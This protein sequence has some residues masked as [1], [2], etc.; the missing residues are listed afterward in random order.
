ML[1]FIYSIV[2]K[3]IFNFYTLTIKRETFLVFKSG[4]NSILLCVSLIKRLWKVNF[5]EI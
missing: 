1:E 3:I 2:F 4:I 5:I